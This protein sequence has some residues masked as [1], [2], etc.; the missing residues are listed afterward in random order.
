VIA[1]PVSATVVAQLLASLAAISIVVSGAAF[2]FQQK[3]FATRLL[4]LGAFLAV[5]ASLATRILK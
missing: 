2:M 3:Q 5:A 4:L 1:A